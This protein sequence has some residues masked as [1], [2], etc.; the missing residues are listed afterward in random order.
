[1]SR[2]RHRVMVVWPASKDL[3]QQRGTLLGAERVEYNGFDLG[4]LFSVAI[5]GFP[6]PFRLPK[7]HLRLLKGEHTC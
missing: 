3:H 5:D 2:Q 6:T 7:E 1:M 4:L